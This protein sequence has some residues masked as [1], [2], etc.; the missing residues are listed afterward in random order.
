MSKA[1]KQ[2]GIQMSRLI[3]STVLLVFVF[4]LGFFL[5]ISLSLPAHVALHVSESVEAA[6]AVEAAQLST[7]MGPRMEHDGELFRFDIGE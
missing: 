6:D 5:V 1:T 2:M 7:L 4:F 3:W